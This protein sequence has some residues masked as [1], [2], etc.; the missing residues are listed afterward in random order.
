MC[1]ATIHLL[2]VLGNGTD[3]A[4][5]EPVCQAQD[6]GAAQTCHLRYYQLYF[7]GHLL[8]SD[9]RSRLVR[10]LAAGADQVDL[11]YSVNG[12]TERNL[13]F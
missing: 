5:I 3:Y 10:L 11:V 12:Y 6:G 2:K 13:I 9:H 8:G 1:K 4:I 7:E